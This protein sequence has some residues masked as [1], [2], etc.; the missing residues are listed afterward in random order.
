MGIALPAKFLDRFSIVFR[1]L[2][3]KYF[4]I[5]AIFQFMA[6]EITS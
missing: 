4:F 5:V 2:V 1:I 6:A 3:G